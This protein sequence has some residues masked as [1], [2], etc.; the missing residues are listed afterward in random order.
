MRESA[1]RQIMCASVYAFVRMWVYFM[2]ERERA[3]RGAR[4]F[5]RG[6][7]SM[8]AN[9]TKQQNEADIGQRLAQK[10]HLERA[11]VEAQPRAS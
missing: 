3:Q 2:N 1:H 10:K 8:I 9:A 4:E 7:M 6:I 11:K 5:K